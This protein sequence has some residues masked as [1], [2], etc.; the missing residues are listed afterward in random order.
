MKDTK[1]GTPQWAPFFGSQATNRLP[2]LVVSLEAR[3]DIE[4][5][6]AVVVAATLDTPRGIRV[7]GALTEA[8]GRTA[9]H[10]GAVASQTCLREAWRGH[11]SNDVRCAPGDAQPSPQDDVRAGP[12]IHINTDEAAAAFVW[13]GTE[14][15]RLAAFGGR[16]LRSAVRAGVAAGEH[17]EHEV[18]TGVL[19][20]NWR[21]RVRSAADTVARDC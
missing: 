5:L 10:R 16:I 19:D 13:V 15:A 3:A 7:C 8:E 1:K 12:A 2:A 9:G 4:A 17:E 20:R 6:D 18:T 21:I 14:C 11:L